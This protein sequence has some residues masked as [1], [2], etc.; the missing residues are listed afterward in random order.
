MAFVLLDFDG[1]LQTELYITLEIRADGAKGTTVVRTKGRLPTAAPLIAAYQQWRSCYG[2]LWGTYRLGEPDNAVFQG[3]PDELHRQ[4]LAA[5][6][7]LTQ[8]LNQWLRDEAF[9]SVREKLLEK[10]QPSQE[11][12]CILQTANPWLR[13]LPWHLWDFFERYPKAEL[14]LS[15]PSYEAVVSPTRQ[16]EKVRILSLLGHSAG[17]DVEHDRRLLAQL[18]QAEV[19]VLVE[20]SRQSLYTA[21]WDAQ[22]WD[23]LCFSGHSY[24]QPQGDRLEQCAERDRGYLRLNAQET[25]HLGDIAHALKK[26][27]KQGLK[28][29]IFNSC[30]GLGLAHQIEPLAIPN[31]IILREP[32]PD[33]VAQSFLKRF[34]QSFCQG[35]PL[36]LAVREG[37]EQ[38]QALET[39]YPCASWLPVLFQHPSQ[40]HDRVQ[41]NPHPDRA[42]SIPSLYWQDLYQPPLVLPPC[43]YRGLAPFTPDDAAVFCGREETIEK[44]A[45]AVYTK[46][47]VALLGASG[48]GKSSLVLAGLL[49][50]LAQEAI[51]LVFRPTADPLSQL[52]AAL[53]PQLTQ[54]DWIAESLSQSLVTGTTTLEQ[55]LTTISHQHPQPRLLLVVDQFEELYTLCT[56]PTQRHAFLQ[57]LL[58]LLPSDTTGATESSTAL[59]TSPSRRFGLSNPITL[60]LTLRADFL[61]AVLGD[62]D[63]APVFCTYPPELLRPMGRV[64][65]RA[66]IEEPAAHEG[67]RLESGLTERI[68]TAVGEQPGNLPLLE[69]TLTLLWERQHEQQLNHA[70]YGAIGGV[71]TALV[72]YAEAVYDALNDPERRQ[73]RQI[74]VQLVHP[75]VGRADTRRLAD[76]TSFDTEFTHLLHH[77]AQK[78]LIVLDQDSVE[79]VHE[80]LITTWTRL[81][82]WLDADRSFRVWQE[83]L[84][85]ERHRWQL[86]A[87]PDNRLLH[88]AALEEANYWCQSNGAALTP[89]EQDYIQASQ[90]RARQDQRRRQRLQALLVT[91]FVTASLLALVSFWQWKRAVLGQMSSQLSMLS[92]ASEQ[93]L[94]SKKELDALLA[95]IQA[96]NQVRDARGDIDPETRMRAI[97]TLQQ[98]VHGI[99]ELNRLEGHER[100]VIDVAYSPNGNTLVSVG[101]DRTVRLWQADGTLLQTM[102][103]HSDLVRSVS[104]H[105]NGQR[106]VTASYDQT[107][108]LW[109]QD[110][111]LLTTLRGHHAQINRVAWRPDGQQI[112]SVDAAGEV[113]IWTATGEIAHRWTTGQGWLADVVWH[114]EDELL[115]I[116][117]GRSVQFWRPWGERWGRLLGHEQRVQ[118]VSFSPDGRQVLTAGKAGLVSRWTLTGTL[119]NEWSAHGDRIWSV[120]FSPDGQQLATSSADKTVKL[121]TPEGELLKT[122]EG[123]NAS[124]Y[125]AAF[126]P[127]AP[128]LATVSADTTIRIW[129][130]TGI[131]RQTLRHTSQVTA[132]RF[133]PQGEQ[134]LTGT[135]T[136]ELRLWQERGEF[137]RRLSRQ[138][139]T[140][141]ALRF[142]PQGE[143]IFSVGTNQQ[144]QQQTLKGKAQPT[145]SGYWDLDLSPD[146]RWLV[147]GNPDTSVRLWTLAGQLH[148]SLKG[149]QASV[150]ATRFSPDGRLLA[151]GS[152]DET[153]RIW[154]RQGDRFTEEP[155][156][157]RG[158]S[159]RINRLAWTTDGQTL[160]SA[161]D[162]GTIRL[163]RRSRGYQFNPRADQV[164]RGH[165]SKVR[166]LA[167]SPDGQILASGSDDGTLKL[168]T[169]Q[170]TLLT[171]LRGHESAV[172][173][174]DFSPDGQRLA[175]ASADTTAILWNLDL[176][177]LLD[178]GCTWL[179]DYLKT[180]PSVS[181][182]DRRLCD[183]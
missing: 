125:R 161:S 112:A 19:Q 79:L 148:Q 50:H 107:L 172:W 12:C 95:S 100:T 181:S 90:M 28:I 118:T 99:H 2:Q 173:D 43:P 3:S 176:Y 78:R 102:A 72:T 25:L 162:D 119:L 82:S 74:F 130:L 60:I 76:R 97:A 55:I 165:L 175:S 129:H 5:A 170:G 149:H 36:P 59:P 15:A 171:T 29:A 89:L 177:F 69:F 48:S 145:H 108:R 168:W 94:A 98:A 154:Q 30:D 135:Q 136:G 91:G 141:L 137:R 169:V 8:S 65:L 101:D 103:D 61:E 73:A 23:I 147:T 64:A 83:R 13:R 62:P 163:W 167:F 109:R 71:E 155:L 46:P 121:W 1:D 58:S 96:V 110:G 42:P 67:V 18:P 10:L 44:L 140:V 80:V 47:F 126:H 174:L 104:W 159:S 39:D 179:Q 53:L 6:A 24:S 152:E 45:Y 105:P 52:V 20:P 33:A 27:V 54:T 150:T 122:L 180:N 178:Q 113:I 75:G 133:H 17:I 116:A 183:L 88:G 151:T 139:A 127:T 41:S 68:L 92:G 14:A 166:S 93:L 128:H 9:R 85:Q 87:Q 84:R 146:G 164:L 31:T 111:Q 158:H 142:D 123:H 77:L 40:H 56:E 21:L 32:V 4:L 160:A 143:T 11:I 63:L 106:F 34:L 7:A 26:A 81:R 153:I 124:A 66:A 114:P 51:A 37:R 138:G 132:I 35:L 120:Q 57:I 156:L 16:R 70:A 117:G 22:G 182:G 49:P 131:P 38:L 86:H 134:L 157:L 115:A 144:V